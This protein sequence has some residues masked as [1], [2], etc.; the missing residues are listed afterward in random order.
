M[1]HQ[2]RERQFAS[3]SFSSSSYP[4]HSLMHQGSRSHDS[5]R[6]NQ[7]LAKQSI[8]TRTVNRAESTKGARLLVVLSPLACRDQKRAKL[9]HFASTSEWLGRQADTYSTMPHNSQSVRPPI[10]HMR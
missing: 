10:R 8:A 9:R 5:S 3:S 2:I 6:R 1:D 7:E 4:H